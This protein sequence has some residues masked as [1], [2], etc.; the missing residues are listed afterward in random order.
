MAEND[1]TVSVRE[2]MDSGIKT[3]VKAVVDEMQRLVKVTSDLMGVIRQSTNDQKAYVTVQKET[4]TLAKQIIAAETKMKVLDT[5]L[6]KEAERKRQAQQKAS[7]E[8]RDNIAAETSAYKKLS[9]EYGKALQK[10]KDL[11]A[12]YGVQSEQ[13][14]KAIATAKGYNDQLKAIDASMGNHQRNVGNYAEAIETAN[15]S[16]GEMK[17]TLKELRN[18]PLVGKTPEEV[19]QINKQIAMLTDE[20]G[21]YQARMR[22]S[23]DS[24]QVMIEGLQGVV[25]VAQGVTGALSAMGYDTEKLDK[26]MVQ[27]IGVSQALATIHELNEKQTLKNVSAVIKDT[28][29][30]VANAVATKG[31]ALATE[32]STKATRAFGNALKSVPLVAI[33]AGIA[34]VASALVV[35]AVKMRQASAETRMMNKVN[36]EAAKS[37]ADERANLDILVGIAKDHSRSIA[38]RRKAIEAINKVSP[39]YLGNITLENIETDKAVIAIE[40]YINALDRKARSQAYNNLLTEKYTELAEE[41]AKTF[42][43]LSVAEQA[44]YMSLAQLNMGS[45][46]TGRELYNL[47]QGKRIG[48]I[49]KEI[50]ALKKLAYEYVNVDDIVQGTGGTGGG[51]SGT[52]PEKTALDELTDAIAA[53]NEQHRLRIELLKNEETLQGKKLMMMTADIE[54]SDAIYQATKR[55]YETDAKFSENELEGLRILDA[56][57]RQL[58]AQKKAFEELINVQKD[59]SVTIDPFSG[60]QKRS[61]AIPAP[62]QGEPIETELQKLLKAWEQYGKGVEDVYANIGTVITNTFDRQSVEIDRQQSESDKLWKRKLEAY[63]GESALTTEQ[64]NEYRQLLAAKT[65][66][67]EKYDK[68]KK[69]LQIR[70]MKFERAQALFSISLSTSLAIMRIL[71]DESPQ[72][73]KP[74]LIAQAIAQAAAQ[75]AAVMSK[76]IPA[77]ASGIESTPKTGAALVGE[78]GSE[79][80]LYPDGSVAIADKPT[81]AILPKGTEVKN[82]FDTED[83]LRKLSFAAMLPRIGKTD[84]NEKDYTTMLKDIHRTLKRGN[85]VINQG[86]SAREQYYYKKYSV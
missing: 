49:Y 15:M 55:Y 46:L 66:E 27:L 83:Y 75:T 9:N 50:N 41:E 62:V 7:K 74:V 24:T 78:R 12:Q 14:K 70:Q 71:A 33:I 1:G 11:A 45:G 25:A 69:A 16:L 53:A 28:Y 72:I 48:D 85:T 77:Y 58:E 60:F 8:Q 30:K 84:S 32:G 5:D 63:E 64:Q 2:F 82:A 54:L 10:A 29:A 36:A 26:A 22:S 39:E 20:M 31:L 67:D 44:Y 42:D 81:V 43:E 86:M 34:A 6:A 80:I 23:G 17:R 3:E 68:Q 35:L 18:I 79:A 40:N 65:K 52:T 37:T 4:E 21:D 38:E 56:K 57:T 13:A 47:E 73:S 59:A 51:V 61:E 19:A 76:P